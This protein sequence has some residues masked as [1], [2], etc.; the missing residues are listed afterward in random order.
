MAKFISKRKCPVCNQKKLMRADVKSCGCAG[1]NP[2]PTVLPDSRRGLRA[3][4]PEK[5]AKPELTQ[6]SLVDLELQKLRDKR[7]NHDS[8]VKILR[9]RVTTLERESAIFTDL[10]NS[11]PQIIDILPKA[12]TGKSESAAVLVWSDWHSEECVLPEQVSGQNEFNLE[13]FKERFW[14]L[15]R[16]NMAWLKI[17]AAE[18][19]IKTIVLAL[20]GDFITG[21][22][23]E[24]LA[25]GNLLAPAP[26]IH[27]AF[28]YIVAGINYILEHTAK[29][30]KLIVPCHSGNHGRMT[31]DQRIATEAGNSLEYFMY[32]MLRDH[33]Q[34]NK[35]IEFIVQ[36]GYHSYIRFFEGSFVNRFHHGHQI[37]YQGGVGGITIPVNKAIA[38]W[39]KARTADLD[40]FGHFHTKFD[41][42]N[43][44]ANGSV[45]GYNAYAV[46]IKASFEEP[47]QQM[48]LINREYAAKTAVM[49]VFVK[50]PVF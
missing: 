27:S 22:I 28:S 50:N 11:A 8:E 34:T 13:V 45:I 5:V 29:D 3:S 40:T 18:T 4:Q 33:F 42:G 41:G 19:S 35:R 39:N 14:N 12:A 2:F 30:V 44:I 20:L 17:S 43:F 49:P 10:Q 15:L 38:Q 1:T 23:H 47:M 32:L 25:E 48:Y 9:N 26:A 37:N 36:N 7:D 46:S 16:G 24:D 6:E 31:K 21:S